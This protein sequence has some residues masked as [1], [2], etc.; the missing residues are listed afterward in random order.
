MLIYV[1]H[2]KARSVIER[3]DS[4][5]S[6]HMYLVDVLP[7]GNAKGRNDWLRKAALSNQIIIASAK[8]METGL[9]CQQFPVIIWYEIHESMYTMDQASARSTRINQTQETEVYFMA[10]ERTLQHAQ[11]SLI[12]S[13]SDTARRIYG[14]LGKTGLSAL[15]PDD[16]DLAQV[17][18]D[19]IRALS[20]IHI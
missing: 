18:E 14:E 1:T 11:L 15:N 17:L 3:L 9:N 2:T 4:L 10:Y 16:T 7:D 13:K 20:L 12:A 19:R 6:E 8:S 5:L